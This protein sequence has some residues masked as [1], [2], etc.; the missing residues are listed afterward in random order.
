MYLLTR[1]SLTRGRS[2]ACQR[3]S[4][5]Q[6][7]HFRLHFHPKNVQY[8]SHYYLPVQS[9]RQWS[10]YSFRNRN[11]RYWNIQYLRSPALTDHMQQSVSSYRSTDIHH[12]RQKA[13]HVPKPPPLF[14][15][16]RH[17]AFHSLLFPAGTHP[18]PVQYRLFRPRR[19]KYSC[20]YPQINS[21]TL[22]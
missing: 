17:K 21:R 12:F 16:N 20:R 10:G 13:P 1:W 18:S 3:I 19:L 22:R 6:L 4:V 5:R 9:K 2:A 7:F 15:D 8:R 14:Q 11:F